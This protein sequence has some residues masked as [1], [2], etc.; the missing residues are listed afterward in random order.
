MKEFC[1]QCGERLQKT[2]RDVTMTNRNY[3][4]TVKGVAGLFCDNCHEIEFDETTD[5][6][7]RIAA[8]Y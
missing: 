2:V 1:S 6:G 3:S 5:S 4:A 7:K 8:A